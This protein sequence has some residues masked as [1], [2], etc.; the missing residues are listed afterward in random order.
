MPPTN[1]SNYACESL[2]GHLRVTCT[3]TTLSPHQGRAKSRPNRTSFAVHRQHDQNTITSNTKQHGHHIIH[4]SKAS[5]RARHPSTLPKRPFASSRGLRML[6]DGLPS[7][8]QSRSLGIQLRHRMCTQLATP[9]LAHTSRR[10]PI[11]PRQE[12]IRHPR[13]HLS[14][15]QAMGLNYLPSTMHIPLRRISRTHARKWPDKPRKARQANQGRAVLQLMLTSRRTLRRSRKPTTHGNGRI[16]Q[17]NNL[18]RPIM[19]WREVHQAH[20]ALAKEPATSA[21]YHY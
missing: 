1:T 21:P 8:P 17:T 20:I 4:T 3:C 2:A 7:I 18:Y 15:P 10:N 6:P 14:Q 5:A 13:R 16:T 12:P 9:R 19:V 11:Y